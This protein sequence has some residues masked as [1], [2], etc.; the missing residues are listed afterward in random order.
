MREGEKENGLRLEPTEI[1][2]QTE[3]YVVT[4]NK[5]EA[6]ISLLLLL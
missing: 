5:G 2:M 4:G 6:F 1:E 3:P